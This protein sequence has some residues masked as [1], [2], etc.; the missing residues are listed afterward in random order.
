MPGTQ[1]APS[2]RRRRRSSIRDRRKASEVFVSMRSMALP[3]E[4]APRRHRRP[5]ISPKKR[6]RQFLSDNQNPCY[7]K[8]LARPAGCRGA[9]R[10]AAEA[11]RKL[12][13]TR[14]QAD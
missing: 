11:A 12:E 4:L 9:G 13:K 7:L 6:R 10:P 8:S 1:D 2:A 14:F 3:A 5:A